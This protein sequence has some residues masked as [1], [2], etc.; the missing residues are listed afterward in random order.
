MIKTSEALHQAGI[1]LRV[2]V[3]TIED[4]QL[5]VIVTK[6]TTDPFKGFYNLPGG[7][8][9]K[10]E[11]LEQASMR[12]I[13]ELT[14][15]SDVYSEQLYTF[16]DPD[17]DS[18]G[19]WIT[20]AYFALLPQDKNGTAAYRNDPACIAL[21][22]EKLPKLAFDHSSMVEYAVARLQAKIQYSTIAQG[23]LPEKFRLTSLQR[24]YEI[25]LAKKLDKR[26]FRKKIAS[27]K[28][29]EALNE[30]EIVGR[31]RPATLYKFKTKEQVIFG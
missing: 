9:R 3:F 8:I 11:S 28:L 25:I 17:R 5:K 16:G 29:L 14:G 10:T 7:F 27:L 20:V 19:W 31:H 12:T 22:I 2:I 24:I 4:E 13:A 23:L 6:R 26:N 21:P 30:K 15:E 1:T 18:N